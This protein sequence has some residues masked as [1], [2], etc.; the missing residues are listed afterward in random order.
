MIEIDIQIH[1]PTIGE[2]SPGLG[3]VDVI[4]QGFM[5]H[6]GF[7][8]FADDSHGFFKKVFIQVKCGSHLDLHA[9]MVT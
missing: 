1:F 7:G 9:Y 4:R 6:V 5:D 3:F 8:L 2:D